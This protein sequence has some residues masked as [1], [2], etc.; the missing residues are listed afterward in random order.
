MSYKDITITEE[1]KD[2]LKE[3]DTNIAWCIIG[4]TVYLDNDKY[5]DY[6]AISEDNP[7]YISYLTKDR[8]NNLPQEEYWSPKKRY[9]T[10]PSKVIELLF[11][12]AYNA[13]QK[14]DFTNNF[15]HEVQKAAVDCS[16]ISIV[17]GD[18]IKKYYSEDSYYQSEG[19]TDE[20]GLYQSCMRDMD[21]ETFDIYTQNKENVGMAVV[22]SPGKRVRGR[23]ILWYP[24]GR[25]ENKPV[26]YDRIYALNLSLKKEMQACLESMG[27]INISPKNP[28][29]GDSNNR[30]IKLFDTDLN[31]YPYMDTMQYLNTVNN[32]LYSYHHDSAN[33]YLTNTDGTGKNLNQKCCDKCG[34][35]IDDEDDVYTIGRGSYSGS[36]VCGECS[37]HSEHYDEYILY[38]DAVHVAMGDVGMVLECDVRSDYR[39][40]Y[41]LQDRAIELSN[42]TWADEDD[43]DVITSEEGESFVEGDEDYIYISGHGHYNIDSRK[44]VEIDG[45]YYVRG[46]DEHIQAMEKD[47]EVE[48][49]S[50]VEDLEEAF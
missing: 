18:V 17:K 32:T 4:K 1:L 36:D 39:D 31:N 29:K 47:S 42:G 40:R 10:K 44:V 24:E 43:P 49:Q 41:I 23:C 15:R 14:E 12:N 37:V 13:A 2:R 9:H 19:H 11:P 6:L 22:L 25:G 45:E 33:Y 16:L 35:S 38:R 28:I 34:N 26:W 20:G 21:S 3:M 50:E 7:N 27:F 5:I 30:M 48:E 8:I 46:S